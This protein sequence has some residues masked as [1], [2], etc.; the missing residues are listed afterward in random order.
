MTLSLL[1]PPDSAGRALQF[2]GLLL[3]H[4]RGTRRH[5]SCRGAL[6]RHRPLRIARDLFRTAAPSRSRSGSPV[7]EPHRRARVDRR[8]GRTSPLL[9]SELDS[10][11]S[12]L[13]HGGMTATALQATPANVVR[14]DGRHA[15]VTVRAD[16]PCEQQSPLLDGPRR[17]GRATVTSPSSTI[18]RWRRRRGSLRRR[19][20]PRKSRSTPASN[21]RS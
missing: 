1:P 4:P 17:D 6:V 20:D 9:T 10:D 14:L 11:A 12:S 13:V 19:R 15:L 18:R 8:L 5:G 7:L 3:A 16:W 21:P 2:K